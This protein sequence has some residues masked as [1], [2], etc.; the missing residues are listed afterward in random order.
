MEADLPRQLVRVLH[1][2]SYPYRLTNLHFIASF[3]V[4]SQDSGFP[5][6]VEYVNPLVSP[7]KNPLHADLTVVSYELLSLRSS[8]YDWSQ[9]SQRIEDYCLR[10][11][12]TVFFPQDDYTS[13]GPLE[14]LVERVKPSAI[15]TGGKSG[16]KLIYPRTFGRFRFESCLT[17]YFWPETEPS[18]EFDQ[19]LQR[20]NDFAGRVTRLP[21]YFGKLANFKGDF[22]AEIAADLSS[23]GFRVDF[24]TN[25]EDAL[26][27]EK[28]VDFLKGSRS[29]SA[30]L[31]GASR[32][33]YWGKEAFW[34]NLLRSRGY[35][36]NFS[37][38]ASRKFFTKEVPFQSLGPRFFESIS[39]GCALVMPQDEYFDG[40][41]PGIHYVPF[42]LK[43]GFPH[44]FANIFSEPER[45]FCI[46]KN[47]ISYL[48]K[49][50]S[51]HYPAFVRDVFAK[52]LPPPKFTNGRNANLPSETKVAPSV[53]EL[54]RIDPRLYGTTLRSIA[55]A[56]VLLESGELSEKSA[57]YK[58]LKN[59]REIFSLDNSLEE[60][61][62]TGIRTLL[63]Q[64]LDGSFH[65]YALLNPMVLDSPIDR[66]ISQT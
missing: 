7:A 66:L 10:S 1:A 9:I 30:T 23:R 55:A 26:T 4:F 13:T 27:G 5:V 6:E 58:I 45:L 47:A 36:E 16:H 28:W 56:V 53:S 12:K 63:P 62:G 44:G 65:S 11:T 33:D 60:I 21:P 14:Q 59:L 3:G 61:L 2:L 46:S 41:S 8:K 51:L 35:S 25:A 32:Q 40:F 29:T 24:S 43:S 20:E 42:Q 49:N 38:L 15:Y 52:E 18:F 64:V 39:S 50:E 34:F 37:F 54:S 19:Y 57:P 17:G 31:G 22:G 48:R